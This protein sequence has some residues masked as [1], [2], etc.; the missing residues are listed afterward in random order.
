MAARNK[1]GSTRPADSSQPRND[2]EKL[3]HDRP[4]QSGTTT[5]SPNPASA[6]AG[7]TQRNQGARTT[8]AITHASPNL[9][10]RL[11]KSQSKPITTPIHSVKQADHRRTLR[12]RAS[13]CAATIFAAWVDISTTDAHSSIP[14]PVDPVC[15]KSP[16]AGGDFHL[17][18]WAAGIRGSIKPFGNP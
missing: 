17:L 13:T 18:S 9:R 15:L 7:A 11:H 6:S 10:H 5:P 14:R 3:R 4:S 1:R 8:A 16:R 2:S 12:H